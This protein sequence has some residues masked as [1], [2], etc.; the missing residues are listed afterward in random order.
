MSEKVELRPAFAWDCPECGRE[1]FINAIVA[2]FSEEKAA[3][4]REEMGIED[5]D[6]EGDWIFTPPEVE[7]KYCNKIFDAIPYK[8]EDNFDMGFL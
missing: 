8:S 2:E 6:A 7:C 1:Q 5:E 3:E 4:L